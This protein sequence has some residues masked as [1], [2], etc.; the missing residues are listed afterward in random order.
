[1][2]KAGN[3]DIVLFYRLLSSSTFCK[4]PVYSEYPTK[5]WHRTYK[6]F[7]LKQV[8]K[9]FL[10]VQVCSLLLMSSVLATVISDGLLNYS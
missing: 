1:M 5:I 7:A 9:V 4:A 2:E 6:K 8:S 10:S 3:K